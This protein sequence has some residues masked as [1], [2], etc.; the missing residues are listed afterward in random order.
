MIKKYAL[1]AL[2]LFS[3]V[4]LANDEKIQ[5]SFFSSAKLDEWK[6]KIFSGKTDY[7]IV[8]LEETQVLK[9]ESHAGASGLFKEQRIDLLKTPYLNWRWRIDS[10]LIGVNE[11]S[12]SGDDYSARVYVIVSGGWAFWKTRAIN[13]VWA[14][15]TAKGSIWPNA[16][17]G[18]NAMML[19]IRS[20]DDKTHTWYQEKRNIMQDLKQQFDTDIRYI[21]AVAI[22]TDTDNANGNATAYYGDIYFSAK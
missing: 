16:F 21:D 3:S 14:G 6:T 20:S 8:Q 17:A 18:N 9:A 1:I 22:M 19:A 4:I 7:E 13:Y 2:I 12:K 5:I 10:R 15:N 11:K